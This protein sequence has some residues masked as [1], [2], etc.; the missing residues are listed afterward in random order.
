MLPPLYTVDAD[1]RPLHSWRVLILPSLFAGHELHRTHLELYR[2][3]RLDE[4]WDSEHNRQF[5]DRMPAIF[6]CP[7]SPG[8]GKTVY[9]VIAGEAFIP[10]AA[11]NQMTGRGMNAM[12]DGTSMTLGIV[13]VREPFNWMDPTAD[14]TLDE[15]VQGINSDGRVGSYHPGGCYVGFLDGTARFLSDSTDSA[16][17]RALGTRAGG[18][19]VM[20]P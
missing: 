18:E 15:L 8:Q 4:P 16:T 3:I 19:R 20:I 7:D 10:A 11:T 5:H 6:R 17:L 9:S 13:E 2:Q 14:I 1:G 12:T